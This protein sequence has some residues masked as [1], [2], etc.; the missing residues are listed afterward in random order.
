MNVLF[1][2]IAIDVLCGTEVIFNCLSHLQ[3]RPDVLLYNLSVG[4]KYSI[5]YGNCF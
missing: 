5:E 1:A 2:I 4:L 3:A